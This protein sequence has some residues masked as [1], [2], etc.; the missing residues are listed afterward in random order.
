[1][2]NINNSEDEDITEYEANLQDGS[3]ANKTTIAAFPL[4]TCLDYSFLSSAV[5]RV[6][7]VWIRR[8]T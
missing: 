8:V 7:V 4:S 6:L 5:S 1:M 3:E 2:V